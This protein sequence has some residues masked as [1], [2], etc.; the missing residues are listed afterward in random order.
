[1]DDGPGVEF[2]SGIWNHERLRLVERAERD[3]GNGAFGD[4]D[5]ADG[6]DDISLPGAVAA[7]QGG[8]ATSADMTFTTTAAPVGRSRCCRCRWIGRK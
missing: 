1:M 5:R 3:A 7:A 2:A 8:L 6:I 4:I